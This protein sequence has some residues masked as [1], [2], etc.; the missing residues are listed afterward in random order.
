[1]KKD[2]WKKFEELVVAV[3]KRLSPHASVK[4]NDKIMGK[5]SGKPRQIDV[6]IRDAIGEFEILIV[7]ECRDQKAPIGLE[8]IEQFAKKVEDVD[9]HKGAF[10]SASGYTST[11]PKYARRV[12]LNLY[13]LVDVGEHEWKTF[14]S[15]PV[16]CNFRVIRIHRFKFAAEQSYKQHLNHI[17]RL[18]KDHSSIELYD[19]KHK[20]LGK[21]LDFVNQKWDQKKM[22]ISSGKH[23]VLFQND[24]LY[25]NYENIFVEVRLGVE[26]FVEKELRLGFLPLEE[27]SGF[28]DIESGHLVTNGFT[29][30]GLNIEEVRKKWQIVEA[31]DKLVIKPIITLHIFGSA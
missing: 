6:S 1:M 26:Y 20:S 17:V 14:V 30:V 31:Q 15:I 24:S 9:A 13:R 18:E 25:L 4:H 8:D 12:G 23:N 2:K 16:L 28:Q 27:I 29:T 21:I 5:L 7:I 11:A 19:S 22:P 10:V 3:Q